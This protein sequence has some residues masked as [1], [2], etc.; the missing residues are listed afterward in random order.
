[1]RIHMKTWPLHSIYLVLCL[2]MAGMA[3]ADTQQIR[4]DQLHPNPVIKLACMSDEQG[5]GIPIPER[6]AV[7]RATLTLHYTSSNNL[8]AELA[9]LAVKING[10]PIA[11]TK[12]NPSSP[13]V[14]V[15]INLPTTYLK[16]GYNTLAFMASMHLSPQPGKSCEALCSPDMWTDIN[17]KDSQLEI[18]YDNIPVPLSLASIADFV[19]DPKLLPAG[20]VNLIVED[21]SPQ[22]LTALAI[23]SS[24]IARRF[25]YR[26]VS[27]EVSDAIRPGMENVLVGRTAFA[28][29]FLGARGL[30]LGSPEAGFIKLFHLPLEQ[31]GT[32]PG[33]VLIVLTGDT[34]DNVKLAAETFANISIGFPGSQEMHAFGIN[35]PEIMAYGGRGVIHAGET[36]SFRTL[37]FPTTT[38]KGIN[39][40][41]KTINFRL[42]ADFLIKENLTARLRLNFAYGAGLHP[43]SALNINVNGTTV[44]AIHLAEPGG[45][46][47]EN[48]QIDIPAYLFKPGSNVLSFGA[49]LHPPYQEC[50]TALLGNLFLTVFDTSTLTFPGMPHFVAM[51]KLELFMLN[52]FPFTRWPDG[53]QS[54][55]F[56]PETDAQSIAAAM[57]LIG[58]MSQKNGH[59]LLSLR[60]DTQLPA[61]KDDDILVIAPPGKVPQDLLQRAPLSL[62]TPSQ[63]P[64]P[65]IQGWNDKYSLAHIKQK[66]RLGTDRGVIMEFQSPYSPG[67]SILL[68][69]AEESHALLKLSKTLLDPEIQAQIQGG[70]ALLDMS[71]HLPKPKVTSLSTGETYTTGKSGKSSW[72]ES[73]LYG[74]PWT[75]YGLI[76]VLTIGFAAALWWG[77][78]KYRATRKLGRTA[79]K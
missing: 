51:P 74:H 17:L 13:D 42:P 66:S 60:I 28:K 49:E 53:F 44:R 63:A 6:W 58:L 45:A 79:E 78:S 64:Y 61:S 14:M 4:L 71:D 76:A 67:R 20:H 30:E 50:D 32:D 29:S 59:P 16:A 1:M 68:I 39:A 75:Y 19:F 9:Q 65:V 41:G 70:I 52:G 73:Y 2:L 8:S 47:F 69:S 38:F 72:F 7:K 40:S 22:S 34:H 33:H 55:I 54:H 46:F 23:A 5:I 18:E 62:G 10:F 3:H 77:L 24:G 43:T 48:Y 37:D 36:Y 25:D 21:R 26:K 57:N 35:I 31:G 15:K 27:F 12:L 11:Q 56:L